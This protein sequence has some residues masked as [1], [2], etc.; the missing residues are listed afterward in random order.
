MKKVFLLLF[1]STIYSQTFDLSGKIISKN[2]FKPISDVNI[3]IQDSNLGV[4]SNSLGL[5]SFS[6]LKKSQYTLMVSA[7]GFKDLLLNI[8]LTE[9]ISNLLIELEREAVLSDALDV[10]GRYPSKH[11]P[12][13]TDNISSEDI[14]DFDYQTM[15]ELF[16]NIGGI[17]VQMEHDNGRNA[18]FS[19]RGSSDYK[20][21]GYNNRVLVLRWFSNKYAIFRLYRL[22]CYAT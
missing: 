11:I 18:N 14:T 13:L 12:Y 5:F 3:I 17:D 16:R 19:I 4:A 1:L 6:G 8:N 22:E 9:N 15:S 2:S 10:V 21:G 7:I 20:P